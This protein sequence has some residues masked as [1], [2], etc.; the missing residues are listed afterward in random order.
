MDGMSLPPITPELVEREI[1]DLDIQVTADDRLM[2][3]ETIEALYLVAAERMR[4]IGI[5]GYDAAHDATVTPNMWAGKVVAQM[6]DLHRA[7]GASLAASDPEW[8]DVMVRIAAVAAAA[9]EAWDRA[10]DTHDHRGD[11]P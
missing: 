3:D 8:R 2:P 7:E 5:H 11:E 6:L 1:A 4:Q 9:V 10:H